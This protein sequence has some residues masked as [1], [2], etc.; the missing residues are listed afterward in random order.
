MHRQ[1]STRL[2]LPQ[3]TPMSHEVQARDSSRE[4]D[5]CDAPNDG[6]FDQ[7]HAL[8][9]RRRTWRFEARR[10]ASGRERHSTFCTCSR[11]VLVMFDSLGVWLGGLSPASSATGVTRN[12]TA[13]FK[14]MDFTPRRLGNA[15]DSAAFGEWFADGCGKTRGVALPSRMRFHGRSGSSRWAWL[16]RSWRLKAKNRP[17][18]RLFRLERRD[19]CCW[20]PF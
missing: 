5:C 1:K 9:G 15:R 18:A 20:V 11:G 12:F 8:P 13:L 3:R 7:I 19:G 16:Q 14:H 4:P 10:H 6:T 2:V 17:G